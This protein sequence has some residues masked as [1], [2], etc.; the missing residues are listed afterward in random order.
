MRDLLFK[1]LTSQDRR[2]KIISSTEV[3]DKQGVHS[4]IHRH[5]VYSIKEIVKGSKIKQGA[6]VVHVFK[7]HNTKE[8][9]ERFFCK[10]KGGI[11]AVKNNR[12]FWIQFIHSLKINL[13]PASQPSRLSG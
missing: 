8:Q 10:V 1:N 2:R 11:F 7:E 13:T 5:F 12:L 4:I 3:L 6:P 9:K